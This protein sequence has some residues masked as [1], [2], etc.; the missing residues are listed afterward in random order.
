MI[1]VLLS[2]LE[3]FFFSDEDLGLLGK[4]KM[5]RFVARFLAT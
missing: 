4:F 1:L 2:L 3:V 5:N